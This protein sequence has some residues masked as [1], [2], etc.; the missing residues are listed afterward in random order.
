MASKIP[1]TEEQ[2]IKPQDMH[3]TTTGEFLQRGWAYLGTN[4]LDKAV[5]DLR[6]ALDLDSNNADAY[7]VL[8]LVYKQMNRKDDAIAAF[9][10][11][12]EMADNAPNESSKQMLKRLTKGHINQLNL[13]DWNLEKEIWKRA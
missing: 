6:K 8:G 9:T 10:K 11:V 13:G 7:F 2:K 5:E 1:Q 12:L 4:E 3:P